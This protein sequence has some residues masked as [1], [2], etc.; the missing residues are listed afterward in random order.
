[1]QAILQNINTIPG[2]MGGLV[3][4]RDGRIVAHNFPPIF[5]ATM[6][7]QATVPL[8]DSSLGLQSTDGSVEL[9]DLRY[10]EG[11]IVVRPMSDAFLLLLCDK[12]INLQLLI[13][14]LNIAVKKLE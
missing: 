12:S 13:I 6:L 8:A 4:D 5:D 10:N 11:R 2:M 14:S 9:L 7:A 1:M 3:C